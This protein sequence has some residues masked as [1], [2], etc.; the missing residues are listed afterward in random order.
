MGFWHNQIV[1]QDLL[2]R[3]VG[4]DAAAVSELY[5]QYGGAVFTVTMS[6]LK[7]RELAADASQETFV[8][9]WRNRTSYDPGRPFGPWLYAIARRAA[10]DVYR[11]QR[12]HQANDTETEVV[13]F[14]PGIEQTWE[15]F[16]VRR[17]VDQL[18]REERDV[19]RLTHLDGFTHAQT[20]ERLGVPVGTV[21]SR[22]S[23]AHQK[24]ASWLRHISEE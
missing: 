15:T 24:L 13:D 18:P 2:T 21:K 23:R 12:R 22:S 3:F 4:G 19:V 1:A 5:A 6:V 17:A 16:E 8:K 7:D 14:P 9:A 10:I 11:S 20:A